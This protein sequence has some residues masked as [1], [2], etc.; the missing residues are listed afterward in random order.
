VRD[1]LGYHRADGRVGIRNHLLILSLGGLTEPTARRIG[2]AI[3]GTVVVA[4]PYSG[5]V[6]GTDAAVHRAAMIGLACHPNVGATLL[7]GDNPR[8]TAEIADVVAKAGQPHEALTMDDCGHDAI[9]LTE[10][11]LRAAAKLAHAISGLERKPAPFGALM[12]GLECGRSDPSSGLVA[13]PLLGLIA[14]RLVDAGGIAMIGETMEWLGAEHLLARRARTPAAAEAIRTAALAKEQAAIDAG[15][16]LT[17]SNPSP[18][19]IAA[20]LSSIEEKSLGNI[21]KSGSR[22]IEGLVGYSETPPSPGMWVMDAPAYA[23]ESLT[24]FVVAGAQ[25]LLFTTGVG[26][27]YVGALA[28]TLK[29]SAN[30]VACASLDTQLDYDASA[31]FLGRA[32]MDEAA[33]GLQRAMLAI[34]SG[35]ATWGEILKEGGEVVSRFGAAL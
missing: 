24:G 32:T 3:A 35:R 14:D 5:G 15:M 27:S 1:F 11:G 6:I 12:L 30:P 4:F 17:G 8:V 21:A 13:N 19:N 28:P 20:G 25:L 29:L 10:R 9:V 34:A 23:P 7:I 26:N 22:P 2:G 33:D 31:V 16:D 18:T